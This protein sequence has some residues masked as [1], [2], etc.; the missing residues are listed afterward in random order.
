MLSLLLAA[1]LT[2]TQQ[3]AEI[4]YNTVSNLVEKHTPRDAGTIRGRIAANFLLD[5]TS[6]LGVN[7]RRDQFEAKTRNGYRDFVNLYC[8]FK[9]N[10]EGEWV[11]I[12]SH[13]DTKPGIKCPGANDGGST[14]GLLVGLANMLTRAE[15]CKHNVL[16]VWTDGEEAQL[17]YGV[18]DGLFGSKR[19]VEWIKKKDYKV[20]AVIC[21]DM[22]GDKN[23]ELSV[24]KNGNQPLIKLAQV[25]GKRAKVPV[26]AIGEFVRDDH[27]PFLEADYKAI[28]LIDFNYGSKPG[29]NDYWHTSE[30]SLDKISV[31]SL[32]KSG[33]VVAELLKILL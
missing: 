20:R 18:N 17:A 31:D 19:A 21:L 10:P 27:V 15:N 30:D 33:S 9:F 16:L 3:D 28:D 8:E 2:F 12:L 22:L 6:E 26:K 32:K 13:Y 24:P 7:V 4:S 1:A 29:L 25:A 23:L 5:S 14:S 11:V